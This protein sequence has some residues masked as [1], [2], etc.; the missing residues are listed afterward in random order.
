MSHKIHQKSSIANALQSVQNRIKAACQDVGRDPA[1]VH[2][3][4]VSKTYPAADLAIARTLGQ[5]VFGENR[6]QEAL[7]KW[8]QL[9]PHP[10]GSELR[11]IGPLQTNKA[12]LAVRHFNV[13]ESLDRSKLATQIAKDVQKIGRQP[14]LYIQ[15]NIGHEPQKAGV[16]P[17]QTE[18]FLRECEA[19][20][21]HISGLMCIPPNGLDSKPFF[22]AL[23]KLATDLRLPEISMGM[24]GDFE[25]AVC[26]GATH[27]RVGSVIFG[28]RNKAIGN[29]I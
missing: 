21:L 8:G 29:P 1:T 18:K 27:I 11:L 14:H 13:I 26:C 23:T 28:A 10:R 19:L 4:A 5:L 12:A 6:V 2:L 15:V 16:L 22:Q 20:D 17:D 9:E 3:T 7:E 24:S 25:E